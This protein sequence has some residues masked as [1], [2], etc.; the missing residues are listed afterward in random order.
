MYI[1]VDSLLTYNVHNL[2]IK[3]YDLNPNISL[4]AG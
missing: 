4:H 3:N 2:L 1:D